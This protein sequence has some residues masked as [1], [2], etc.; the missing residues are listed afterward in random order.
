MLDEI[1]EADGIALDLRYATADNIAGRPVYARPVAL[2][3]PEARAALLRARDLAAPLCLRPRV[4]DAFRPVEAQWVFWRALPDP[5]FVAD[6]REGGTH[7]RGIAVDLTL[8]PL[9]GGGS[10]DM[11]TGFDAMVPASAHGAP[12]VSAEAARNRLLLAG[13]MACAGFAPYRCEWWHYNLPD[14]RRY[15]PLSASA[16]GFAMA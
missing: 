14:V 11:G 2:L 8:E 6:P 1:T 13:V 10:L 9:A 16:V 12:G 15:P 3:R 7:P 5:R 4:F